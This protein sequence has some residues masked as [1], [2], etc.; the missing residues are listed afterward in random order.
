MNC[1]VVLPPPDHASYITS[2]FL[3]YLS[4]KLYSL[5]CA[6]THTQSLMLDGCTHTTHRGHAAAWLAARR[7]ASSGLTQ[8]I[9]FRSG[10]LSEGA[11][12][13]SLVLVYFDF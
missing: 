10:L 3:I 8:K 9:C 5:A 6:H 13:L 7:E 2:S 1:S 12:Q 11:R 4:R